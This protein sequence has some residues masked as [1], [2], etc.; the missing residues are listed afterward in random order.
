MDCSCVFFLLFF[1]FK[2]KT[3]SL[4]LLASKGLDT[5]SSMSC[6]LTKYKIN[7]LHVN[8]RSTKCHRFDLL[9]ASWDNLILQ[10][11][12]NRLIDKEATQYSQGTMGVCSEKWGVRLPYLGVDTLGSDYA[13]EDVLDFIKW[14]NLTETVQLTL[15]TCPC[16]M[17]Q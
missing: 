11:R 7:K 14:Y 12:E 6:I 4:F 9:A 2:D 8:Y 13:N 17:T 10:L 15:N 1:V 3:L 16:W 5:V